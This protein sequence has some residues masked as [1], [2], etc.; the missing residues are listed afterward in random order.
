MKML[1][2]G[3]AVCSKIVFQRFTQ[4]GEAVKPDTRLVPSGTAAPM[5]SPVW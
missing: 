5:R 4:S 3:K 1:F 2:Q